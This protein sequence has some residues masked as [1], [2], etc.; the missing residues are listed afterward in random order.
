MI[1]YLKH[2]G[3]YLIISALTTITFIMFLLLKQYPDGAVGKIPFLIALNCA[4]AFFLSSVLLVI[5]KFKLE[6][7]LLKSSVLYTFF[8]C[9]TLIFYIGANPIDHVDE[10]SRNVDLWLFLS[11][12]ISVIIFNLGI[13]I[14]KRFA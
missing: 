8:Y 4:I 1:Y 10:I 6:L 7:S 13:L 5:L 12:V 11:E 2:I 3:S 9:I 14:G